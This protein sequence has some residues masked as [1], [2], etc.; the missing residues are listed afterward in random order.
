[1]EGAQEYVE[2]DPGKRN[3]ARPVVAAQHEDAGDDR[4]EPDEFD[5]ENV[6]LKRV[7]RLEFLPV[8]SKADCPHHYVHG[9]D[10][11][12]RERTFVHSDDGSDF[13]HCRKPAAV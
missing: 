1:M 11:G 10:D 2:R 7:A 6:A 4:N 8:I 9:S 12:H 5:P 3:P 13:T